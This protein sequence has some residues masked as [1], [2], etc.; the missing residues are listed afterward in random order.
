MNAS[1]P[2]QSKQSHRGNLSFINNL[3]RH[4][5]FSGILL[6]V[7]TI[8]ALVISNSSLSGWYQSLIE[9]PVHIKIHNLEIF[10]DL[11]LWVNDGLMAIFFFLI[12]LEVKREL[13]EGHLSS[14]QKS[15]LAV[16]G[17]LGGVMVPS[18][19]YVAFNVGD[20]IAIRG[21]AIPA[22]TD[23]AFALTVVT[24]LGKRV[25][26]ALKVFLL[27]LAIIDDLAAIVIIAA[28]Y[29]ASLN[30]DALALA[31]LVYALL[32]LINRLKWH[33]SALYIVGG[34]VLWVCV[35]KSGI[36]AT[37]AGVAV[38]FVIP[39]QNNDYQGKTR[40]MLKEMEVGLHGWVAYA[41]IPIFAFFNAGID[42]RDM[43]F[44]LILSPVPLGIFLGLFV[45]KQ[46]GV[47]SFAYV[48][49]KLG[50]A[51]MPDSARWIEFYG[52]C[53]LT[54]IGFTMSLFID[55]LAFAGHDPGLYA[56]TERLAILVASLCSAVV[57]YVI[58]RFVAKPSIKLN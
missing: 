22:A 35:L 14:W 33:W 38:A 20:P 2:S 21:W 13:L 3:I 8:V 12:G 4:E 57:G 37:L 53:V 50:I 51:K 9:V 42:L 10:K 47:F 24:L 52:I 40:S 31:A 48:A 44:D 58:I 25:P 49:I 29:T 27:A 39:M 32:I 11:H 15:S 45:G 23:I 19:I 41:V 17:A 26:I 46:L 30:F 34:I 56:F 7:M 54:G 1:E 5:S 43:S 18:L 16:I 6:I 36:H 55:N 28:F